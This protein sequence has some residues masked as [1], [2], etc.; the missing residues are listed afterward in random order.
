MR[1][2]ERIE[3]ADAPPPHH[4]PFS[5]RLAPGVDETESTGTGLASQCW[6]ERYA[7]TVRLGRLG[8]DPVDVVALLDRLRDDYAAVRA[9]AANALAELHQLSVWGGPMLRITVQG[10]LVLLEDD[11]VCV[12]LTARRSLVACIIIAVRLLSLHSG[13]CFLS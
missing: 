9:A 10:L 3:A 6:E 1:I 8:R 7:A 4:S 2:L 12:R 13:F 11:E 5:S